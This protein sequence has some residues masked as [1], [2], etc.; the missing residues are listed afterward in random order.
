[1]APAPLSRRRDITFN[2]RFLTPAPQP[3]IVEPIW[4]F[5]VRRNVYKTQICNLPKAKKA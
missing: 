2:E 3:S 1:M 4:Q 5:K